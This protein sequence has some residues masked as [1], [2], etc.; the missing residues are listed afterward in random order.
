MK[1]FWWQGG[2]HLEPASQ[3][4]RDAVIVLLK[5]IG[6]GD[7]VVPSSTRTVKLC[8]EE[9]IVGIDELPQIVNQC[10]RGRI[11]VANHPLG[12]KQPSGPESV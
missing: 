3:V 2:L 1:V 9:P 7:E 4:E 10:E 5:S 6:V 12:E 8:N 11:G